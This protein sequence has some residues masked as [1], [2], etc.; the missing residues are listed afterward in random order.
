M[1]QIDHIVFSI[2]NVLSQF[3]GFSPFST[4]KD[5]LV[6]RDQ[7]KTYLGSEVEKI[8]EFR[9]RAGV[10]ICRESSAD[11]IFIGVH[12]DEDVRYHLNN[13]SPLHRVHMD[14]LDPYWVLI[15]EISHFHLIINRIKEKKEL[16]KLELEWQGEIDK[17]LVSS[18]TFFAQHGNPCLEE[19]QILL[20]ESSHVY[21]DQSLEHIYADA[22]F[23]AARFWKKLM[24]NRHPL[25]KE[26]INLLRSFYWAPWANKYAKLAKI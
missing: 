14:N 10:F 3:Y 7:L 4:V 8:P 26:T 11:E 12:I 22:N 5:H 15:E 16:T 6:S 1:T 18:L 25:G 13:D 2:E 24:K 17:L 23:L 19:L 9:S 21:S 20:H